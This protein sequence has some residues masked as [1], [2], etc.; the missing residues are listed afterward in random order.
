MDKLVLFD[1]DNTLICHHRGKSYIPE[2]TRQAITLLKQ[3]GHHVGLA[4]G[5]SYIQ[6]KHVMDL[7]DLEDGVMFNG[8]MLIKKHQVSRTFYPER[9]ELLALLGQ[10]EKQFY[11]ALAMT[12]HE[13]FIKDYE[14]KI[15]EKM[16]QEDDHLIG[17]EPLWEL[18]PLNDFDFQRSDYLSVVWFNPDYQQQTDYQCL[19]FNPWG[20]LGYEIYA[21]GISKLTGVLELAR[22]YDIDKQDIYVFGDSFND[23]EMLKG[24]PHSVAVGNG[25]ESIKAVASYVC[26]P[27]D[28]DG[29]LTACQKMGLI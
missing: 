29:I 18:M 1:V 9:Q 17:E 10:V 16:M 20:S 24:I 22:E 5:R 8:H 27:I 11:P 3:R 23:V 7:L 12:E 25:E 13:I 2:A 28:E 15:K 21:K 4:T 6:S 19:E 26:P 14:G